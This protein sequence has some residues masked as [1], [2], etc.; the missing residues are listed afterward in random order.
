MNKNYLMICF[1]C[2]STVFGQEKSVFG[3]IDVATMR[4]GLRFAVEVPINNIAANTVPNG[5]STVESIRQ[6]FKNKGA[7]GFYSGASIE[8]FRSALW[9]P[10]MWIIEEG[11]GL[12]KEYRD[13]AVAGGIT[14]LEAVTMPLFRL[15]TAMMVEPFGSV[16]HNWRHV[17]STMYSGTL[18]RSS[19]TFPSWFLLNKVQAEAKSRWPNAPF[20]E[21][22]AVTA[23]QVGVALATSPIYVVLINR[24]KL[25]DPCNLPFL[26]A[27]SH[28]YKC[29]G[30]P[31]FYRTAMFG[32]VHLGLQGALTVFAL[33]IGSNA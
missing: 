29:H 2:L 3:D 23:T 26:E 21:G 30:L 9:Y 15:R 22:V 16:T 12:P 5:L 4:A 7:G 33:H 14:S 18:L 31:V 13:V 6:I 8:F 28:H 10:R 20:A 24:Q 17:L 32:A 27:L 11:K 1:F 25:T 19:A